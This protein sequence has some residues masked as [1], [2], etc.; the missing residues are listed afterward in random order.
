VQLSICSKPGNGMHRLAQPLT[1]L[2]ALGELEATLADPELGMHATTW[3]VT[4]NTNCKLVHLRICMSISPCSER[5]SKSLTRILLLF[6]QTVNFSDILLARVKQDR[7]KQL[8]ENL[9][10]GQVACPCL[11]T[12]YFDCRFSFRRPQRPCV[13]FLA[14]N[15]GASR[16]SGK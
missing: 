2:Y 1:T 14:C 8:L 9:L 7:Q 12:Q 13:A 10:H 15:P 3:S 5:I 4:R 6:E 11:D 16:I